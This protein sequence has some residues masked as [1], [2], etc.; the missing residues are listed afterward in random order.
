MPGLYIQESHAAGTY[1]WA[2]LFILLLSCGVLLLMS[3]MLSINW[4]YILLLILIGAA[5]GIALGR[6]TWNRRTAKIGNR[7]RLLEFSEGWLGA[8]IDV[9]LTIPLM[10][11]LLTAH[12]MVHLRFTGSFSVPFGM[13]AVLFAA[14][15]FGYS[16]MIWNGVRKWEKKHGPI[17]VEKRYSPK[18]GGGETMVGRTG[19]VT[20][21]LE[22]DGKVKLGATYWSARSFEGETIPAGTPVIVRDIDRLCVLVERHEES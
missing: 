12:E 16:A 18:Y 10:A 19:V 3:W 6:G 13:S 22:P 8:M 7:G 15:W 21:D 17:A 20:Q 9:I 14:G 5:F 4:I 2:R 1:Q 11:I